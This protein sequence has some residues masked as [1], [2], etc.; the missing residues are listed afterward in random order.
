MVSFGGIVSGL[1]IQSDRPLRYALCFEDHETVPLNCLIGRSIT[2][3]YLDHMQC[4]YCK[5]RIKKTYN[6]GFCF[7]C[8]RRLARCDSC[9]VRPELCH[10]HLGTCREPDWGSRVCMQRHIVYLSFT[11]H[12]KVGITRAA[13]VPRRWYDQGAMVA[14]PIYQVPTRRVSGYL[15]VALKAYFKDKTQWRQMLQTQ[16]CAVDLRQSIQSV[17]DQGALNRYIDEEPLFKDGPP[18]PVYSHYEPEVISYPMHDVPSP[19]KAI[20]L[21]KTPEFTATLLGMKGQYLIFDQAVFNVKKYAGYRIEC[22][23][24]SS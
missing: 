23:V 13:N 1:D 10:F 19:L 6:N 20:N 22:S 9:I 18:V 4:T 14:L 5:R 7:L 3:R 15:E 12:V 21:E 17:I 8:F 24:A 16:H 2:V 11:S